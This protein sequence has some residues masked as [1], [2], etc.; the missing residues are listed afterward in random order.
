MSPQASKQAYTRV[1]NVRLAQVSPQLWVTV[2]LRIKA[3]DQELH[4]DV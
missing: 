3:L 2:T 4:S 1:C